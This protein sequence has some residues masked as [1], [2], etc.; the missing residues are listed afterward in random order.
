MHSADRGAA[1]FLG[2]FSALSEVFLNGKFC[3]LIPSAADARVRQIKLNIRVSLGKRKGRAFSAYK[4]AYIC[5]VALLHSK[6]V[7]L[8]SLRQL[9]SHYAKRRVR[10]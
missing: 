6:N 8:R 5:F 9:E 3:A 2:W 10:R 7:A 4:M 1:V